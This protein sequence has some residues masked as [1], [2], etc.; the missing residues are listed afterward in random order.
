[1]PFVL[2]HIPQKPSDNGGL[3]CYHP[4]LPLVARYRVAKALG[5]GGLF[6]DESLYQAEFQL[7]FVRHP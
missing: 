6:Q 2:R 3:A 5:N 7:G 1:V 4:P